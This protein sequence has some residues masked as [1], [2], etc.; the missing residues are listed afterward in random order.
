MAFKQAG[1]VLGQG[2]REV[3][4]SGAESFGETA[5]KTLL[6]G[7]TSPALVLSPVFSQPSTI[8]PITI[9]SRPSTPTIVYRPGITFPTKCICS[10][11][12][13]NTSLAVNDKHIVDCEYCGKS[14]NSVEKIMANYI[15]NP[16]H[17][18]SAIEQGGNSAGIAMGGKRRNQS[19]KIR[20]RRTLKTRRKGKKLK[21]SEASM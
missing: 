11:P 6:N 10:R 1:K 2:V 9:S 5:A 18:F 16:F 3:L 20:K 17:G 4:K 7:R 14:T 8:S 15:M 13:E 21:D 19:R 12:S